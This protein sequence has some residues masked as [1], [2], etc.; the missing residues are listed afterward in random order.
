[1]FSNEGQGNGTSGPHD[2]PQARGDRPAMNNPATCE[3]R[4]SEPPLG[5]A[6][7]TSG[8]FRWTCRRCRTGS[9]SGSIIGSRGS[10]ERPCRRG[11][12]LAG[13]PTPRN[14]RAGSEGYWLSQTKV[15]RGGRIMLL[16]HR[17]DRRPY[18]P[19]GAGRPWMICSRSRIGIRLASSVGSPLARG[20]TIRKGRR[21]ATL[22]HG[23]T[24]ASSRSAPCLRR[25]AP[26]CW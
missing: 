9:V 2:G 22:S 6:A 3:L 10:A 13:V 7:R 25:S 19:G 20:T 26:S 11:S 17:D 24:R 4:S 5:N 21:G 18:R 12:G 14:T 15:P 8:H 23:G 1:M 16:L